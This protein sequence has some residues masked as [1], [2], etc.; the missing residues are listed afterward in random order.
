MKKSRRQVRHKNAV[1]QAWYV[2]SCVTLETLVVNLLSNR[3]FILQSEFWQTKMCRATAL[4]SFSSVVR[5]MVLWSHRSR[6]QSPQGTCAHSKQ[7]FGRLQS[8]EEDS[9][10]FVRFRPS[11]C[12]VLHSTCF[13][14]VHARQCGSSGSSGR[15]RVIQTDLCFF[16]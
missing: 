12:A 3:R 13:L 2:E 11:C 7:E 5:A 9:S 10:L 1:T 8:A 16:L 14:K 15:C 6:V 4:A